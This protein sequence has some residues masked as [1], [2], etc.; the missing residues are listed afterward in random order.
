MTELT[1]QIVK[2]G[3]RFQEGWRD[4]MFQVVPL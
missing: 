1:N 4:I 2:G 3:I